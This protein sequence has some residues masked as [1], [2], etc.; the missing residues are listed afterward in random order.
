[1]T[2]GCRLTLSL[3][4]DRRFALISALLFCIPPAPVILSVAY[5]E[6]FHA[7]FSF[8]GMLAVADGQPLFGAFAFAAGTAFRANGFLN[9]GFL[10]WYLVLQRWHNMPSRKRVRSRP[11]SAVIAD[12]LP[13]SCSKYLSRPPST[14]S[15]SPRLSC[16]CNCMPM[17][18][19]ADR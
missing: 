10:I 9:A 1:M 19:F 6:P 11:L 13:S 12:E 15:L 8:V 2:Y 14:A 4:G 5:T 17:T 3:T 7:L 18:A 16:S